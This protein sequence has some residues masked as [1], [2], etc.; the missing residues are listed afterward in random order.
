MMN[1]VPAGSLL[2]IT[3]PAT[4]EPVSSADGTVYLKTIHQTGTTSGFLTFTIIK[5]GDG[6]QKI[7]ITGAYPSFTNNDAYTFLEFSTIK[8]PGTI[9]TSNS[10]KIEIWEDA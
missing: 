10:F 1:P 9:Q 2:F 5:Q 4:I 7:S 3:F 8:N 6:S